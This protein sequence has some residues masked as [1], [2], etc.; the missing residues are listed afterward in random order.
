MTRDEKSVI[1]LIE[2]EK[3]PPVDID[4]LDDLIDGD[5]SPFEHGIDLWSSL[6]EGCRKKRVVRY[7]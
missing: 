1:V 7:G 5:F 2:D 4:S 6:G 3:T